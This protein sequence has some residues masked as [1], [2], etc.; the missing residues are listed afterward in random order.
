MAQIPVKEAGRHKIVI[1]VGSYVLSQ[2]S[3]T[4]KITCQVGNPIFEYQSFPMP[5]RH[6]DTLNSHQAA[7][8]EVGG[9]R[10]QVGGL[11]PSPD[12]L[13]QNCGGTKPNCIVTYMMPKATANDMYT[14]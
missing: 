1:I 5:Q 12:V 10:R 4:F 8:P 6:R 3:S 11:L 14:S 13:S 2:Q 9:K 7:S